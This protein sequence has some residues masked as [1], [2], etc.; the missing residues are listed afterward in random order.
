ML[1]NAFAVASLQPSFTPRSISPFHDGVDV[2][3]KTG[4][5]SLEIV[6]GGGQIES[7]CVDHSPVFERLDNGIHVGPDIVVVGESAGSVSGSLVD[8]AGDSNHGGRRVSEKSLHVPEAVPCVIE[9]VVHGLSN[10]LVAQESGEGGPDDAGEEED[11]EEDGS[12]H[13]VAHVVSILLWLPGAA[14]ADVLGMKAAAA[15]TSENENEPEDNVEGGKYHRASEVLSSLSSIGIS[16]GSHKVILGT[17]S[18]FFGVP[19]SGGKERSERRGG[20]G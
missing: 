2:V 17:G 3:R 9:K 18:L 7:A 16:G 6:L 1:Y 12:A 11:V 19:P 8:E 14:P 15:A 20:V 10:V 5:G 13:L 4:S